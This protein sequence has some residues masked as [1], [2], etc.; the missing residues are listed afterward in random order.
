MT[1]V[2]NLTDVNARLMRLGER[3]GVPQYHNVVI[4]HGGVQTVLDP[5]PFF[6]SPDMNRAGNDYLANQV[7]LTPEDIWL[8]GIPRTYPEAMIARGLYILYATQNESGDWIGVNAQPVYIDRDE[9]L[10]WKVLVQKRRVR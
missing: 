5:K 7:K 2:S 10:T 4:D 6:T 9:T 3:F 1:L 8:S